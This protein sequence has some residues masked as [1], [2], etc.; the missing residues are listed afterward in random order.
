[1]A[2]Q[3]ADGCPVGLDHNTDL[4]DVSCGAKVKKGPYHQV[5]YLYIRVA[6]P[7]IACLEKASPPT[8]IFVMTKAFL[9]IGIAIDL[10]V[11][12]HARDY[13]VDN[14]V[15]RYALVLPDRAMAG[16]I[17]QICCRLWRHMAVGSRNEYFDSL[18]MAAYFGVPSSPQQ[19]EATARAMFAAVVRQA[20]AAYPDLM[21]GPFPFGRQYFPYLVPSAKGRAL[22]RPASVT[23]LDVRMYQVVFR[24]KILTAADLPEYTA[25]FSPPER[26][27]P[28]DD[29]EIRAQRDVKLAD[30]YASL[31]RD[32]TLT[33]EQFQEL[34]RGFDRQGCD[35]EVRPRVEEIPARIEYSPAP[36]ARSFQPRPDDLRMFFSAPPEDLCFNENGQ[37]IRYSF[38]F[39][40][41]TRTEW[42]NL[43]P[44]YELWLQ[45]TNRPLRKLMLDP[46]N[47]FWSEKGCSVV[48]KMKVMKPCPDA[49]C[50][51]KG[52]FVKK[53][54]KWQR[55]VILGL[56]VIQKVF[57][58]G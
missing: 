28:R 15:F 40:E 2:T 43:L 41:G 22:G 46:E 44:I 33:S 54:G 29:R 50:R 23:D 30:V 48:I 26:P 52:Q 16:N 36:P 14:G 11:R 6:S 35:E 39:R 47:A 53:H 9:K 37:V 25:V 10:T 58:D 45:K 7:E 8:D 3:P 20:H 32:G 13:S 1:M 57:E 42:L 56:E 51:H 21:S 27:A 5:V 24:D 34:I 55:D 4:T 49:V 18:R 19:Y 12:D 31:L 17:E 38:T